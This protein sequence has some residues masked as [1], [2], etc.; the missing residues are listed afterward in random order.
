MSVRSGTFPLPAIVGLDDVKRALTVALTS[1]NVKTVLIQGTTGSAKT[2]VVRSLTS[3]S[4][5]KIVNLPLGTSDSEIFGTLDIEKTISTG[6]R[7]MMPGI[8]EKSHGNILHADDVNLMDDA[9]LDQ[10]LESVISGKVTVEKEGMSYEYPCD[11]VFIGTMNV[12]E[13]PLNPHLLDKFDI[14]V[15]IG[16]TDDEENRY[17]ILRRRTEFD[18]DPDSFVSSYENE[19]AKIRKDIENAR[20][21][22]QYVSVNDDILKIISE[23]CIKSGVEGHRGD[24]AVTNVS[25]AISA[26]NGRDAVTL[27][28]MKE[29][30]RLCLRHRINNTPEDNS[31]S[32]NSG[33]DQ[34]NSQPPPMSSDKSSNG[35]EE[36]QSKQ[37]ESGEGEAAEDKVFDI[38]STF[39]VIDFV[40]LKPL[41]SMGSSKGGGKH[42]K[43]RS[44]DKTG[45][46][47]K[48][49]IPR[50]EVTDLAFDA[51]IRVAAPYQKY[52]Q[53]GDMALV[54][55]KSDFRQ[56]IR[57]KK[58]GVSILFVVDASGSMGARKRMVA[59]K[60][61]VF[62]L[63]QESYKNRDRV[64][65]ISFRADKAEILLPFTK[66]VDFAYKKLKEM[67]T[68]GTT[69]L[70]AAM[71]K[72]HLEIKKEKRAN[73]GEK[74]YVILAT[75]GRANASISDGDPLSDAMNMGSTIGKDSS[76]I[77]IVVDTGIGFPHLDN[78]LHLSERLNGV[79]LRLEDLKADKLAHR[80]KNIV[81]SRVIG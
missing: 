11:A 39:S 79:Y 38:G 51:S 2:T 47:I 16:G 49:E 29:A 5:K 24:L 52:R 18:K 73:P 42:E 59:V 9:V 54:L 77:W 23:L 35:R 1:D 74:C 27:D 44:T 56:K 63:L 69:P 40:S 3:I 43:C 48:S 76:A 46:Y 70:A 36:N 45:R 31:S 10:I 58:N 41:G 81:N 14:C 57:E 72:A 66:S 71:L 37:Q 67:P 78:A 32:S 15:D 80:I 34:S 28:D 62:S 22:L 50:S 17:Q 64:G 4:D 7:H 20:E 33:N 61:A 53:R 21:R 13:N 30:A 19:C 6:V 25:M 68:G 65:L 8:L 12:S 75:D 26:L 60:G 55:E